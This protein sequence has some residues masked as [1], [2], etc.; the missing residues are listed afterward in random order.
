MSD[1]GR[2]IKAGSLRQVSCRE[3]CQHEFCSVGW[4]AAASKLP[5][6]ELVLDLSK[7]LE[8]CGQDLSCRQN[9][10]YL[11]KYSSIDRSIDAAE[12]QKVREVL[13]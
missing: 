12:N 9:S 4:D 2:L 8:C 10:R 3:L 5:I 11:I 7:L 13:S 1:K 6:S